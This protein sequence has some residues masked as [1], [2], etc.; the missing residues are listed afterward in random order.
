MPFQKGK[1]GNPGGR[2]KGLEGFREWLKGN[3]EQR[4]RA[5]LELLASEDD[6][7]RLAAIQHADAYDYGKP[8][9]AVDVE[10]SGSV[11][12]SIVTNVGGK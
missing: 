10:H 11:T 2:P 5:L 3:R 6:R 4:Q 9:Q 7:V 1:S 12:I 8:T